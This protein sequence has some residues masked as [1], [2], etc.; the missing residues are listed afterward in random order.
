M[1][2][3]LEARITRLE[4]LVGTLAA[5]LVQAQTGFGQQDYGGIERLI[6][7]SRK[8]YNSDRLASQEDEE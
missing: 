1:S 8:K 6:Q 2:A 5:W 7:E 4:D 3:D